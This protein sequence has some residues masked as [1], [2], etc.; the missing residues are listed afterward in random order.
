M[1]KGKKAAGLLMFRRH[2]GQLEVLLAH[3]GGPLWARK[4]LG[5][6]T[7]PKGEYTDEDPLDAAQREFQ[8]ETGFTP[9]GPFLELSSIKQ[10]SGKVVLAWAFEADWD[11]S[12]LRSNDFEMEWPK[13]SGQMQAFP[14]VERAEWFTIDEARRRML[15]AQEPL[16]DRLLER[17]GGV[18]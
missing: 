10:K 11:P 3:P 12:L 5:A 18:R 2:G 6:W 8:E 16:L 17:V 13:G 14:E 15:P 1:A 7:I 9:S 4:D